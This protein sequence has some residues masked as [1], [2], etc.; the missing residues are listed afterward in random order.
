MERKFLLNYK[1]LNDYINEHQKD[2]DRTDWE[3]TIF[4]DNCKK[5]LTETLNKSSEYYMI[6][7]EDTWEITINWQTDLKNKFYMIPTWYEMNNK[8]KLYHQVKLAMEEAKNRW[9]YDKIFKEIRED[10]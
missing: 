6:I 7:N 5:Y 3:L 8:D 10:N 9:I 4:R 1:T 2:L